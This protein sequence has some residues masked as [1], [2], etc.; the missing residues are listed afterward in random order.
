L[1]R[2]LK[3]LQHLLLRHRVQKRQT[4]EKINFSNDTSDYDPAN[5]AGRAVGFA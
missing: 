3:Q 4:Y 1:A 2:R 5:F